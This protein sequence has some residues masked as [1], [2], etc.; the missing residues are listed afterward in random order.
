[1]K[2]LKGEE[3]INFLKEKIQIALKFV[4]SPVTLKRTEGANL[5]DIRAYLYRKLQV[6]TEER[7]FG[8]YFIE[9]LERLIEEGEVIV[10]ETRTVY[11]K[12]GPVLEVHK[13]KLNTKGGIK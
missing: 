5:P 2:N 4:R 1:M 8:S 10:T 13:V 12:G 6:D 3:R 9:A 7:F 11:I